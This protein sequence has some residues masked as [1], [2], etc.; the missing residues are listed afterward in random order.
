MLV[1]APKEVSAGAADHQCCRIL[2]AVRQSQIGRAALLGLVRLRSEMSVAQCC[3][4]R[5]VEQRSMVVDLTTGVVVGSS[6]L[7]LVV[8]SFSPL[9][10]AFRVRCG[11]PAPWLRGCGTG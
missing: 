10:I 8:V 4:K 7:M 11:E 9:V 6:V 3:R 5:S 2:T 1:G